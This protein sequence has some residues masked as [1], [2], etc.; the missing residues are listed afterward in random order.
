[1]EM[2]P[3]QSSNIAAIG[4]DD[5]TA[6]LVIEFIKA[7]SAYE[8]YDVPRFEFDNLMSADSKGSYANLN[9]YKRYRQQRIR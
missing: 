2:I 9:I 8:Y 3:V 7:S 1:M 4:Y 6:I 5:D